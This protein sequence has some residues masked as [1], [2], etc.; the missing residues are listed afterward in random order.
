MVE[1]RTEPAEETVPFQDGRA[2]CSGGGKAGTSN[3][4]EDIQVRAE[5]TKG[6]KSVE[7]RLAVRQS[8]ILPPLS[9]R[10]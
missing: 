6:M 1:E 3:E 4:V 7:R 2:N 9:A 5:E 8:G 10:G